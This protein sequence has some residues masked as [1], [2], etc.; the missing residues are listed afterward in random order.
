MYQYISGKI[1]HK[2]PTHLVIDNY[3]IGYYL[4]ISLNTF[5]MLPEINQE[6]KIFTYLNVKEE[7]LDLYGFYDE[8]EKTFFKLILNISGIGPRVALGIISHLKY[9]EFKEVIHIQDEDILRKI[10]GVGKKMASRILLELKDKFSKESLVIQVPKIKSQI[11]ETLED[12]LLALISLGYK[13]SIAEKALLE[14]QK[15]SMNP[16]LPVEGLIKLALQKLS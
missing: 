16:S 2:D 5:S 7:L 14:V 15:N 1:V 13:R 11:K 12:A 10:P 8:D 9:D 3:G 4:H 6:V